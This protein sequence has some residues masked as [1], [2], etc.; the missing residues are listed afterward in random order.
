MT[1]PALLARARGSATLAGMFLALALGGL[2]VALLGNA[3]ASKKSLTRTEDSLRA[4]EAAETGR[5]LAEQ[6]LS[7]SKD[8]SNDGIGNVTGT[9]GS[10]SWTVVATKDPTLVQRWKVTSTGRSG[11]ATRTIEE[12]VRI[13]PNGAFVE[14][15]FSH[16]SMVFNGVNKTDAYYSSLGTYA[17]QAVNVDSGGTYALT[18]G[19]IG[20]NA[21]FIDLNGSSIEIRG[22][23]IPGPLHTVNESGNPIVTGDTTPRKYET[24]LPLTPLSEF[25]A[26]NSSNNNENW[27][28]SGGNLSYD[29]ATKAMSYKAGGTLTLPGGTY[30]FSDVKL[31]G[32]STIKFTGP[33]KIYVTGSFDLGGG[34][35]INTGVPSDVMIFAHPYAVPSGYTPTSTSVSLQG[36]AQSRWVMYGP[37]AKLTIG[38]G[39]E[40]YGAAVAKS[41]K[42]DGNNYFHY[43]RSL[44][45]LMPI[46]AAKVE[47]VY[48][49]DTRVPN[50]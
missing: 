4:L 37:S 35:I 48:W 8:T 33:S 23:A 28:E 34:T 41:I 25:Q 9:L 18:G 10:G 20:S 45:D 49:L 29:S 50:R 38:G 44:D 24:D 14:G 12:G 3:V 5:G 1:T 43:D 22:D 17:S 27:T 32:N 31:T 11:M 13:R 46:G 2:S 26:A 6:E 19:N 7:A 21:G 16:D 42:V 40:I 39:S 30:F 47:H 15:L 36:G